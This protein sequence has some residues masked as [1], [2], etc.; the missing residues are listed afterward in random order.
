[1]ELGSPH[2]RP[3]HKYY[4]Q[5]KVKPGRDLGTSA[6]SSVLNNFNYYYKN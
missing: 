6:H 1:M 2:T 5:K 3:R 4:Y